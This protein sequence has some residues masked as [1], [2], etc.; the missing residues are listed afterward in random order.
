MPNGA[1]LS[2]DETLQGEEVGKNADSSEQNSHLQ[3]VITTCK[4]T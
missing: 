4:A 2:C 1:A 3:Q